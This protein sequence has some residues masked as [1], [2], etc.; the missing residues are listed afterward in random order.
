[1]PP[2][3]SSRAAAR[4]SGRATFAPVRGSAEATVSTL[5]EP[6]VSLAV[7]GPAAGLPVVLAVAV[8]LGVGV[9]QACCG[10]VA[11]APDAVTRLSGVPARASA[12]WVVERRSWSS[13]TAAAFLA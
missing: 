12:A 10:T 6:L 8:V 7:A 4:P 2:P 1:A 3:M 9:A 11:D 13:G 5:G